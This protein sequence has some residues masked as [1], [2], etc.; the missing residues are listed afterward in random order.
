MNMREGVGAIPTYAVCKAGSSR[1]SILLRNQT[2]QDVRLGKGQVVARAVAANLIPN[3]ITPKYRPEGR[4]Y[5]QA[6]AR[7]MESKKQAYAQAYALRQEEN[8]EQRTNNLLSK[9]DLNGME[10]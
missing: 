4:A 8:Q 6:Y 5:A 7:G 9:L 10:D 3:K 1:V 2:R